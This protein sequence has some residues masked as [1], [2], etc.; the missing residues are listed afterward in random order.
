M[1]KQIARKRI[2]EQKKNIHL[3]YVLKNFIF[4]FKFYLKKIII[5]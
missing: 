1:G 4:A 3:P 2:K 5:I